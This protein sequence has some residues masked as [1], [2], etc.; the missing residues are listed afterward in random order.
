MCQGAAITKKTTVL[1]SSRNFH[2][3]RRFPVR[4]RYKPIAPAGKTSPISPIVR[5]F[6]AQVAAKPQQVIREGGPSSSERRKKYYPAVSHKPTSTSGMRNRVKI[7][8]PIEV[9]STIPE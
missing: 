7:Y 5:T 9:A 4:I 3:W 1:D 8:G 2:K 6:R